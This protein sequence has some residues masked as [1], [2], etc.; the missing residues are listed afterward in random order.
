MY[1]LTYD[2]DVTCILLGSITSVDQEE[3]IWVI[4]DVN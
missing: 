1:C 2:L 3:I 4:N